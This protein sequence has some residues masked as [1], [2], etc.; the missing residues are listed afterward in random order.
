VDIQRKTATNRHMKKRSRQR[1]VV[2]STTKMLKEDGGGSARDSWIETSSLWLMF[3]RQQ[4]IISQVNQ[5]ELR[6]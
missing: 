6:N 4:Q 1:K 3:Y 2:S 5:T